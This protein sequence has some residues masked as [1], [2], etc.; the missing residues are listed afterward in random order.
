MFLL[1]TTSMNFSSSLPSSFWI[2]SIS[3][4]QK[5][6]TLSAGRRGS[7]DWLIRSFCQSAVFLE[8]S[9]QH[10]VIWICSI[11]FFFAPNFALLKFCD[12]LPT[13][14]PL[15]QCIRFT[16]NCIQ[17]LFKVFAST[18]ESSIIRKQN[19]FL[20]T[21]HISLMYNMHHLEPSTDP[22]GTPCVHFAKF[23]LKNKGK[24][25]GFFLGGEGWL[26]T[27]SHVGK[28]LWLLL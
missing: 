21:W 14:N 12:N 19:L 15:F 26:P 4:R 27:P 24:K 23:W 20:Q 3:E 6:T 17:M 18:A 13:S 9:I 10:S 22:W 28:S 16:S 5:E 1:M 11:W 2:L 8:T 25:V 7:R